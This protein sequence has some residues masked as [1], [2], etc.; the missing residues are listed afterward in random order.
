MKKIL[1]IIL[2]LAVLAVVAYLTFV[3]AMIKIVLGSILLG[4][5]AISL[6]MVW[7]LWKTKD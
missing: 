1:V 7:I 6:L 3:V 4:I 2:L 5:S